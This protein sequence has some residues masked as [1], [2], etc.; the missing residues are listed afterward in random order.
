VYRCMSQVALLER[1]LPC[2]W[3]EGKVNQ[4]SK[5][6]WL[7]HC[8]IINIRGRGRQSS[9]KAKQ[10]DRDTLQHKEKRE[11]E[12]ERERA[13]REVSEFLP[14]V[15][16]MPATVVVA[17]AAASGARAAVHTKRMWE[18]RENHRSFASQSDK[19]IKTLTGEHSKC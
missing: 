17:V 6:M 1:D 15:A 18:G 12:R 2:L 19:K 9:W 11:R 16:P 14:A 10:R 3:R 8:K 7:L 5:T 4:F 13:T